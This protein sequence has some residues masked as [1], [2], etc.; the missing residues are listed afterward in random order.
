MFLESTHRES[1]R[2][3]VGRGEGM[4]F[5]RKDRTEDFFFSWLFRLHRRQIA[6]STSWNAFIILQ[7]IF[8][9]AIA[10]LR[11]PSSCV[12]PIR[13]RSDIF[14]SLSLSLPPLSLY[15]LRFYP[16]PDLELLALSDIHRVKE[17]SLETKRSRSKLQR[18]S[19]RFPLHLLLPKRNHTTDLHNFAILLSSFII[20]SFNCNVVCLRASSVVSWVQRNLWTST[21]VQRRR[22]RE[23]QVLAGKDSKLWF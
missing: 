8:I 17:S 11:S 16:H 5:K 14:I 3:E 21:K 7:N 20:L 15:L 23:I 10:I 18:K 1:P 12:F 4:S 13:C 22:K 19:R 6:S 9:R 2:W